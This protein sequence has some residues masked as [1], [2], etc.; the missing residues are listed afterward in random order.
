MIRL[1]A[2]I[3]GYWMFRRFG[4]PRLCPVNLTVSVTYRCNSR[5]RTCRIYAKEALEFS[6]EEYERTFQSIGTGVFWMTISGGEPFLR[7]DIADI[8]R[9]ASVHC[10]P[11]ILNIP[12]NGILTTQIV[13]STERILAAVAPARVII[14]LSMDEIR[15]RHDDIRGVPGNYAKALETYTALRSLKHANLNVGI[16]TVIS[17]FNAERFPEIYETLSRLKPDAYIT[18]IAEERV[19]LGTVGLDIAPPEI[20]YAEAIDC[21]SSRVREQEHRGIA[22]VT[23]SFR[24]QYYK[25]VKAT[26]REKRQVLPC[27]AGVMSAQISPAGDVWACC[28]KAE[29]MGNLRDAGYDFRRV[30]ASPGAAAIRA[31]VRKGECYCP[32]ANASYTNMLASPKTV[33]K[34]IGGLSRIHCSQVLRDGNSG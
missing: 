29:S 17:R 28:I 22:A 27:Y 19:E 15:E 4:F 2:K 1:A 14:N 3:P 5:C 13:E 32:L 23:Q 34:V 9:L 25:I 16:H 31:R 12:T 24:E 7:R 26:L 8:C 11:S 33:L 21:L 30:W 6:L 10:K 18:E 20:R